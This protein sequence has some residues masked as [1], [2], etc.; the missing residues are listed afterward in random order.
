MTRVFCASF[1][2]VFLR[3]YKLHRRSEENDLLVFGWCLETLQ[4]F[5]AYLV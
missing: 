1:C 3:F 5:L 4:G 2:G